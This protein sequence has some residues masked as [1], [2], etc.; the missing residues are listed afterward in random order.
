M[1]FS[2]IQRTGSDT[3]KYGSQKLNRTF[4][5]VSFKKKIEW[6]YKIISS[7]PVLSWKLWLLWLSFFYFKKWQ[8][9]YSEIKFQTQSLL[10]KSNI[11]P[12]LTKKPKEPSENLRRTILVPLWCSSDTNFGKKVVY[13]GGFCPLQIWGREA[14][15]E[16]NCQIFILHCNR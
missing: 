10:I 6:N 1:Q 8:F 5:L 2:K 12:T 4:S 16:K 13:G 7:L 11:H 15:S 9:Y 14:G 3:I